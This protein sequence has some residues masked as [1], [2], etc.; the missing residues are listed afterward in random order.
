[1]N[2]AA[3]S[4]AE[5]P[6]RK[7]PECGGSLHPIRILER[8]DSQF[9]SNVHY[10]LEY[11]LEPAKKGLIGSLLGRFPTDGYLVGELCEQCGRVLLRAVPRKS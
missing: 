11:A 6:S 10:D 1:M 8:G 7:C 4:P 5:A 3:A 9:K 2:P